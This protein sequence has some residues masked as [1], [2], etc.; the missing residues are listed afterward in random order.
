MNSRDPRPLLT[1]SHYIYLTT[2]QRYQIFEGHTVE[3]IGVN[4]PVW[5]Q[6]GNTS[7]PAKEIFCK[8]IISKNEGAYGLSISEEGYKVNLESIDRGVDVRNLLDFKDKGSQELIAK[9]YGKVNVGGKTFNAFHCLEIKP[10]EILLDTL[11][12]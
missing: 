1:I 10:L 2:E 8:Y 4:T 3:V 9:G 7:E 11:L 12:D 5:F 6:A